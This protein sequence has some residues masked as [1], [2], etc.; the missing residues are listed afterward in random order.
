MLLLSPFLRECNNFVNGI[1][2]S[3]QHRQ[4]IEPQCDAGAVWHA[5]SK[6]RQ[7]S[8]RNWQRASAGS[9]ASLVYRLKALT[10]FDRVGQLV[11]A[12]GQLYAAV[13]KLK[14]FRDFEIE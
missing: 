2:V 9:N 1:C 10:K 12:I 6:R 5:L 3:G 13:V 11:V 7:Q 4:P 14:P 8:L